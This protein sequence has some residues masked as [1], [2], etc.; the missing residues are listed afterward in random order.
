MPRSF[1]A[2]FTLVLVA[3]LVAAI[4]LAPLA[5]VVVAHAGWR[6][7]FPRIFD[8]T[9]MATLLIAMLF[10]AR[11]L[12]L[13]SL[14]AKGFV[15]L[16]RRSIRYSVRGFV[17]AM[18]AI[19]ILLGLAIAFGGRTADIGTAI[20]LIPKYLLAAIAIAFIEE[21]FFRAFLLRGIETDF[22][23]RVALIA[24]AAIYAVAHLVRS[25]TR[26]YVTGYQ[27]TAGLVTLAH[28]IDQFKDPAIAIPTLIGLFLL[29][30]VLGEAYILT[31]SV[32]FS[33]G[34]HCGFVVGAK[35][36]P[37]IILNRA[38]VPWWIAG[39]GAIPLI[40]GAVAWVIAIAIFAMLRQITGVRR[41]FSWLR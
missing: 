31:G 30:I 9:V 15:H 7:P 29:G 13:I 14:M 10:A 1:T 3:G 19:A 4:I 2:R 32:Y 24:S 12:K 23:N 37:K 18:I 8:R 6:F 35:M 40:G 41:T 17:V 27:P 33:I 21:A 16:P 22:G 34:L 28:S 5:A 11:D 25:P 20:A 38:V 36:W 39:G 26:F